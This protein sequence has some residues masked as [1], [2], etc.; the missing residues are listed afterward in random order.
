MQASFPHSKFTY[1]N[2]RG[3]LETVTFY[4]PD[5]EASR[6]RLIIETRRR[7]LEQESTTMASTMA[8]R[9][10]AAGPAVS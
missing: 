6:D 2:V 9:R 8:M 3:G 7:R 5:K 1:H 4:L 10:L